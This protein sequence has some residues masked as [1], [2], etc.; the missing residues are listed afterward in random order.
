[1]FSCVNNNVL[2]HVA[3]PKDKMDKKQTPDAGKVP[4][5]YSCAQGQP[6]GNKK[7]Y[8]SIVKLGVSSFSV[9]AGTFRKVQTLTLQCFVSITG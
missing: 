5:H 8:A 3:G 2:Q 9:C 4:K 6:G 1:M 7:N